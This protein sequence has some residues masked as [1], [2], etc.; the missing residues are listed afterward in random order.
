[1]HGK[2]ITYRVVWSYNKKGTSAKFLNV[3]IESVEK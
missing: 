2:F 1:M 3:K